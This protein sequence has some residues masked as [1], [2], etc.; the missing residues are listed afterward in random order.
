MKLFEKLLS[1]LDKINDDTYIKGLIIEYNVKDIF[2]PVYAIN[3]EV[4]FGNICTSFIILAYSNGCKW[5][6]Y[7]KD[8]F[9]IR[10]EILASILEEAKIE[11][12]DKNKVSINSL[13]EGET[14]IVEQIIWNFVEWQKDRLFFTYIA[15]STQISLCIKEATN[16]FGVTAKM[17]NDRGKFLE[18]IRNL[19]RDLDDVISEI[20][21][22]N[23]SLDEV[24]KQENKPNNP[25]LS[26][27]LETSMS[28]E[29]RVKQ[30]N[31]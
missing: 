5:L 1:T 21:K 23:Q 12:T 3:K 31:S 20:E 29:D 30:M 27:R 16:T 28:W 9:Q 7:S 25:P 2:L 8:R 10:R 24:L 15:L 4:Q 18:N 22:K 19:E 17:L 6:D 26:K 13:V 11:L 14:E